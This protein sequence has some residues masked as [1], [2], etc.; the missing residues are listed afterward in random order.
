MTRVC[1]KVG[2]RLAKIRSTESQEVKVIAGSPDIKGVRGTDR[3]KYLIDLMR[4]HPRD[5]NYPE[6][7]Q[8]TSCLIRS[9]LIQLF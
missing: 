1:S 5:A 4:V 7:T 6:P 9:E 3:R 8:Q 2:L